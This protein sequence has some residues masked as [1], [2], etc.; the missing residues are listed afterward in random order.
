M[1]TKDEVF[2]FKLC[3]S[4]TEKYVSKKNVIR[5]NARKN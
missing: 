1:V 3:E 4:K 5:W 2:T